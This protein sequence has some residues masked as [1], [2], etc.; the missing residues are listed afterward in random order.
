[1]VSCPTGPIGPPNGNVKGLGAL[2]NRGLLSSPYD[3]RG[4]SQIFPECSR[5]CPIVPVMLGDARLASEM[6]DE[7]L[8]RGIYAAP[9]ES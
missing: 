8:K 1:M 3:N 7:M 6:A 5:D 4:I 2:L 9:L